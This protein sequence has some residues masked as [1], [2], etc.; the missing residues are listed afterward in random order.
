MKIRRKEKDVEYKIVKNPTRRVFY[1]N[2]G[3]MPRDEI[4]K[5]IDDMWKI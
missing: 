5:Y 1:Q 3:N 2:V 4:M